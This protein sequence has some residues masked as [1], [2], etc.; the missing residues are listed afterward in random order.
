MFEH[1]HA[2]LPG[3]V[4]DIAQFAAL[5]ELPEGSISAPALIVHGRADNV[6]PFS[7]AENVCRAIPQVK[8][9]ALPDGGHA[10]LFTHL[11]VVREAEPFLDAHERALPAPHR[12][13]DPH[14]DDIAQT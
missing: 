2:R 3:T 6:V 8:L 10:A 5:G 7:H 13:E 11:N 9:L 14:E 1:L 4:N 12:I